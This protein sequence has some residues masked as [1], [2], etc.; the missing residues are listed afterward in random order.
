[1][2]AESTHQVVLRAQVAALYATAWSA[3]LATALLASALSVLFYWKLR[4]P[5]VF[6]WAG[7][8][9][10]QLLRHL[11]I[12]SDY[13]RDPRAPQRSDYW[14]NKQW[15]EL[16]LHSSVWGLAP[17]LFMPADN[18]PMTVV[19]LLLILGLS[20]S[21][22]LAVAPRWYSVLSFVVP[23]VVGLISA[24]AWQGD[25]TH[26][27]LAACSAVYL[28]ATLHFAYQQHRLLTDALQTRFEK[29]E[30]AQ[31]LAQQMA[32]IKHLSEEKTRFFAAASHDLR[33][34]LHA[35]VLYGAVLEKKLAD[36][37]EHVHVLRLMDAVRALGVSLDTMFDV[38]LLDAG[39]IVPDPQATPL[40]PVFQQLN[41]LFASRA[42]Q[43]GLQLRLR[44]SP[45]WVKT[46][47]HLLFRMLVNLVENAIKYTPSGG[48]LVLARARGD[49]VW[50]DVCD[51]GFGIAA[52]QLEPIFAEFYQVNNPGR[53]RARGLGIGL[54]MVR[55]LA[56]LLD[57]PVTV[58]SRQGRG[59]RFR[60]QLPADVPPAP[61][62]C[63]VDTEVSSPVI[64]LPADWVQGLPRRVLLLD[65]EAGIGEAALAL[66][67]AYGVDLVVVHDE[68]GATDAFIR[69]S[70]GQPIDALIFDYR[71]AD[72]VD[73]LEVAA[74][75]RSRFDPQLPLLLVTGETTP[76]RLSRARDMGVPLLTKPVTAESLLASLAALKGS[77]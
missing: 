52:D 50:V 9:L 27:F 37:P 19:M 22:V 65:D 10:L 6:V 53:D 29:E 60:L 73:G 64:H 11:G 32:E 72:G 34:P 59:S 36:R 66:F 1:M 48:V 69:A 4:D 68:V 63:H 14:A 5:M 7:L 31:Q 49:Y 21:G 38:S 23:M 2:T 58:Q 12:L 18:L 51:T 16:L 77:V 41:Q 13:R 24:L 43:K 35:I 74:G 55:R 70:T 28:T 56:V 76:A 47:Q 15:R 8:Q 25:D 45:L 61:K 75:L 30:L 33:Q 42:E 57:H 71:L 44:A 62:S 40:T 39:F 26:L 67:T 20:S 3:T 17:W 54:S 46:D